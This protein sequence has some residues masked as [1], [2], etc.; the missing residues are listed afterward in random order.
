MDYEYERLGQVR[1]DV[2]AG[3]GGVTMDKDNCGKPA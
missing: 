1:M 2:K 3:Y